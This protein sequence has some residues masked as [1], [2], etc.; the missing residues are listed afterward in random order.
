MDEWEDSPKEISNGGAKPKMKGVS[1][2]TFT[3]HGQALLLGG[4]RVW[5]LTYGRH[6]ETHTV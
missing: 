2:V 5:R 3:S 4:E 6:G 1:K